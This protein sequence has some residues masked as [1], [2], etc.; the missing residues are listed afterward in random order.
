[1]S[2]QGNMTMNIREFINKLEPEF[3]VPVS[4][5]FY[6]SDGSTIGFQQE[7][8][9]MAWD[10]PTLPVQDILDQFVHQ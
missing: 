9:S 3:R 4:R 1:M 6:N 10:Y 5:A 2:K 7:L 8:A